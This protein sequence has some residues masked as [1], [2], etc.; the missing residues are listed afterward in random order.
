MSRSRVCRR[1][2]GRS[3]SLHCLGSLAFSVLSSFGHFVWSLAD[4]PNCFRH[5]RLVSFGTVF[6]KASL[7]SASVAEDTRCSGQPCSSGSTSSGHV[8]TS[9]GSNAI[10][11]GSLCHQGVVSVD[12]RFS[13]PVVGDRAVG[14]E[15]DVAGGLGPLSTLSTRSARV[16]TL[17]EIVL[18]CAEKVSDIWRS[19]SEMSVLGTVGATW[20]ARPTGALISSWTSAAAARRAVM[21]SG[22]C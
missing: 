1:A 9:S 4:I 21:P 11:S 6:E 19:S 7:R 18:R 14:V 2:R 22:F 15:V 13:E 3:A 20:L 10:R 16:S 5:L 12:V 8:R 17:L